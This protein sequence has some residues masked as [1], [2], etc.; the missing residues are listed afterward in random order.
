MPDYYGILGVEQGASPDDIKR[1][2]RKL[3]RDSH[4]DA[5]PDDPRAEERFKLV[6]EAYAVLSDP[7]KRQRYDRF[8]DAGPT[9]FAGGGFGDLG[10]LIDSFFGGGGF[11]RTRTRARTSAVPGQDIGAHVGVTLEE[12]V[13]GT[14]RT[15]SVAALARC[16][17][18]NGDGA[19]PGTYRSKCTRCGG[20]GEIRATQRTILGTVM[21][22]RPCDVCEGSGEAPTDP[23]VECRGIGRVR[24][25]NDVTVEIP[26]GVAEGTTLR[27][28]GRG[29][30]GVRGGPDGDL[31]VRIAVERHELFVRDGDNLVC[32]LVVPLTA[33]VLGAQ[34]EVPTIDGDA[35]LEIRAGTQHGEVIRI[36]GH[37]APR[38]DGRARGDLLVRA[39][40]EIPHK[41]KKEE[42]DLFEQ[43]AEVRARPSKGVFRRIRDTI[44]G[45]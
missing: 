6:A 7:E 30:A 28:R 17:R 11:G 14:T 16:A 12:V 20:Q 40:V 10:D 42:R 26:P 23:C 9:P 15:L 37:G 13:S 24:A 38:L 29:E 18:C 27:L 8:G 36:K 4:P 1:A 21:T 43:L 5:N 22:S 45:E 25:T 2:Y 44:L 31:F 34:M 41:L 33:A 39:V 35:T 3:A 19:E 32:E